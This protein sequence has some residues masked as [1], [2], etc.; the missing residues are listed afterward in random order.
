MSST[1]D[2][3]RIG[4]FAFALAVLFFTGCSSQT[5]HPTTTPGVNVDQACAAPQAKASVSRVA[6]G[7]SITIEGTDWQECN[8]T[9]NDTTPSAW[10]Y[11]SLEWAQ[12]DETI[13]LGDVTAVNG[14]FRFTATI[15]SE[16][17]PGRALIRIT[18]A[19][20]SEEISVTVEEK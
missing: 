15:P 10:G 9:P 2:R 5:P 4:S 14:A 17:I 11:L 13:R 8:D 7:E 1:A 18:A 19:E 3:W 20:F 6:R 12:G 16:A